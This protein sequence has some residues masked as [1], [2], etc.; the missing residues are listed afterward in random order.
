MSTTPFRHFANRLLF[1]K[2]IRVDA[3]SSKKV[4]VAGRSQTVSAEVNEQ[5][6][7]WLMSTLSRGRLTPADLM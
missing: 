4:E 1:Q 7:E 6:A 2:R 3:R 5:T